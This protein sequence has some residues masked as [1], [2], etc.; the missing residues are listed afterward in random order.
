MREFPSASEILRV[1]EKDPART[2]RL[3]ELVLELGLRSS[4]ARELKHALKDLS[5]DRSILTLKKGHFTLASRDLHANTR[6]HAARPARVPHGA[7]PPRDPA[8]NAVTGRLI[9]H[10]DGYGFVV[11][12]RDAGTMPDIFI[13]PGGMGSALHGDRVEVRVLRAKADG[14]IEGHILRVIDRAQKTLVGE[15]RCGER[16]N[17]VA[18]FDHRIP[19][20]IVIPRGQEWP[21][22]ASADRNRQFGGESKS[23]SSAGV[24]PA[25]PLPTADRRLTIARPTASEGVSSNR[26]SSIVNRQSEER[27]GRPRSQARDVRE[28]DGMI[29]DVEITDFPRP[30]APP[31]GRVAEVLGR[32]DDF[33]VD[34]EIVIRKFHLP[35]RFPPEVL[36]EAEETP[37]FIPEPAR[38]GRRD[39]RA[40]PIVTIDGESAKDFDDAVYVERLLGGNYLLQVHIADVAH[41]VRPGMALDREARLRGTSVYFP[42]RAVPML[43]LELSYGICSLNPHVE[44]LTMSALMEVDSAGRVVESE[45]VPGII[46][47]A[48]RMTY[49]AVN[50]VLK[51]DEAARQRYRA[52]V[53]NF[54][55]M[56]ELA[57]LLNQQRDARGSIDFDLPEPEIEFDE[58]GR[59]IGIARSERN[60]A[61]RIIEEFMLVANEAVA[62]YLERQGV[63][64]LYRIHERPDPKKVIEFEEIAATFGYSLGVEFPAAH[65]VRVHRR[66]ERERYPRFQ[67]SA[68]AGDFKITSRNY[69]RLTQR[70]AGK[71]EERILSYLMLRSLKQACYREENVGHFALA[72]PTYTHFTSPIRRYPDLIV[73]RILKA[74]LGRGRALDAGLPGGAFVDPRELQALG[75]ETSEAERRAADAER[76]LMEWKKVSFMA[77]RLGDEFDALIISLTKHGLY[78][79]LTDLFVEGFVP[80]E[81]LADDRY[82]YREKMRAIVG[83]H[84]RRAYHLGERVKVCLDRIDRDGNKLLFT[85]PE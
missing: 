74:A 77:Q 46:R 82:V 37:Q 26:Q 52:L 72:S 20:A 63:P 15:F 36:A 21:A 30:G 32:R 14:R 69:Q 25:L 1:F 76:E 68:N 8:R 39:F 79:E 43:P 31:L 81:S 42:D 34:V 12:D 71:P 44:R 58:F 5:R 50:A 85:L 13:P 53:E 27:A 7:Q 38:E 18:P 64:A 66:D 17:T 10:R 57:R 24:S 29:V 78:V 16:A 62:T 60:I 54:K 45:L 35:H 4:Q 47:S 84:P 61:H 59:M 75:F 11:P 2:F 83:Q 70:I 49:T 33:G 80:M 67:E 9:G 6:D 73:H 40:L 48:E 19:H 22:Q 23:A 41:Y 56:E 55:L 3:R 51:G 28:L 65:R